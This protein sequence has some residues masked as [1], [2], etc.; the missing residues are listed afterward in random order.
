MASQKIDELSLSRIQ[1]IK[2]ASLE[3]EMLVRQGRQ[4]EQD[5]RSDLIAYQERIRALREDRQVI[6]NISGELSGIAKTAQ[7]VSLEV[8]RLDQGLVRLGIAG[9]E[10]T[11]IQKS[12]Q[13]LHG[14]IQQKGADADAKLGLVVSK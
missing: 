5:L 14:V 8:E 6:E 4:A 2:D 11:E 9:R 10:I 13:N 7:N 12:V 3:F 1:S